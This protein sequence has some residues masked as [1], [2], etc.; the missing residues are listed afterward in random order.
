VIGQASLKESH[1]QGSPTHL[2]RDVSKSQ[3]EEKT[4]SKGTEEK[5][6]SRTLLVD[7]PEKGT[8][9][10]EQIVRGDSRERKALEKEFKGSS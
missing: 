2:G 4:Q 3:R 1:E 5:I 7:P 8:N 9:F 6:T 10:P